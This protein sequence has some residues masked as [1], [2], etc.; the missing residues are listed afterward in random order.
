M[1]YGPGQIKASAKCTR[2]S[3][4]LITLPVGSPTSWEGV[5]WCGP[6]GRGCTSRA[7]DSSVARWLSGCWPSL[8]RRTATAHGAWCSCPSGPWKTA[9]GPLPGTSVSTARASGLSQTPLHQLKEMWC[10]IL[11]A[12]TWLLSHVCIFYL[13]YFTF[14]MNIIL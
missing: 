13:Y 5:L 14:Y 6:G 2:V 7:G 8:P 10:E 12:A 4:E 3:K 11:C 9:A 1:L